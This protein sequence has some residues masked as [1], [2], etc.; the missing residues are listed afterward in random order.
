MKIKSIAGETRNSHEYCKRL[1]SEFS[2]MNGKMI[3]LQRSCDTLARSEDKCQAQDEITQEYWQGKCSQYENREQAAMRQRADE[4]KHEHRKSI[5]LLKNDVHIARDEHIYLEQEIK[6][7][8]MHIGQAVARAHPAE[9]DASVA[10]VE[11]A[12]ERSK[13]LA[14]MGLP[15]ISTEEAANL[16]EVITTLEA[17]CIDLQNEVRLQEKNCRANHKTTQSLETELQIIRAEFGQWN[18]DWYTAQY[19]KEHAEQGPSP[20]SHHKKE[21]HG[22]EKTEQ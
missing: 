15:G 10:E 9:N 2:D 12:K 11:L 6:N 3:G 8:Q 18:D 4:I 20:S 21:Q 5:V 14:S 7:M 13:A 1:T 17:D 16:K 19:Y 22:P